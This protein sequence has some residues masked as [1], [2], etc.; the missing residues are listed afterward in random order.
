MIQ[1]GMIDR[2]LFLA[3]AAASLVAGRTAT[4]QT[5]SWP[6]RPLRF[7]VGFSAGSTPDLIARTLAEPLSPLVGRDEEIDVLLRRWASAKAGDGQVV[8]VSGEPGL[9]KSRL[10]AALEERL[11]LLWQSAPLSLWPRQISIQTNHVQT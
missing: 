7:V 4:A 8:L 11:S 2:R 3:T 5:A 9:G 1:G 6:N 10:A